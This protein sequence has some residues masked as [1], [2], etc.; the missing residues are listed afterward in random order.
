MPITSS[1]R[2]NS[3]GT[4]PT[5]AGGASKMSTA[6]MP[7]RLKATT[8][9]ANL[10]LTIDPLPLSAPI[11]LATALRLAANLP[12]HRTYSYIVTS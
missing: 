9:R 8:R 2:P 1:S 7:V 11:R 3:N 10:F 4:N 12:S 6:P 5:H